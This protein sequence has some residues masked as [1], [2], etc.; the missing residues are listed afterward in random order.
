M[1]VEV[2]DAKKPIK[3]SPKPK[4]RKVFKMIQNRVDAYDGLSYASNEDDP[5]YVPEYAS[6]IFKYL[7]ENEVIFTFISFNILEPSSPKRLYE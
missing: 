7:R 5:Q 4:E 2:K 6:D 1:P 3:S